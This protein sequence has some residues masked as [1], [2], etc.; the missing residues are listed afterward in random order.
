M[1]QEREC[2][3]SLLLSWGRTERLDNEERQ[4]Q[5]WLQKQTELGWNPVAS[6]PKN[7]SCRLLCIFSAENIDR[8]CVTIYVLKNSIQTRKHA[9]KLFNKLKPLPYRCRHPPSSDV[10]V[11]LMI[12]LLSV[13]FQK[14]AHHQPRVASAHKVPEWQWGCSTKMTSSMSWEG[15]KGLSACNSHLYWLNNVPSVRVAHWSL[16]SN[17]QS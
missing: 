7:D 14:L 6:M 4:R 10:P 8:V 12:P 3:I 17:T 1:Y 2:V 16:P 5:G 11:H 15:Q 13:P 9:M